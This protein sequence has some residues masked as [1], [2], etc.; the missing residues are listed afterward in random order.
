MARRRKAGERSTIDRLW[1]ASRGGLAVV[2]IFSAFVNVLKFAMP[3]YLLQVLDRIPASRSL[4]T[5]VM[6]TAITAVALAA[7]YALDIV[8]GRMMG[9]WSAWIEANLG[10]EIMRL[11]TGYGDARDE[12]NT[13]QALTDLAA[14]S[15]FAG[16]SMLRWLDLI[17]A[18]VFIFGVYL[19]HPVLGFVAIGATALLVLM[20][21]LQDRTTSPSRRAAS[22]ARRDGGE[23]VR[24]LDRNRESV[25]GLQ[26]GENLTAQWR[27]KETGRLVERQT[28]D[29]RGDMFRTLM[30]GLGQYMRIGL[31]AVGV[32]LV[33]LDQISLGSIFAAR[34]M[35]GFGFRLVEGAVRNW[36]GTRE[37]RD[38]YV[39]LVKHLSPADAA[40]VSVLKGIE[41][42]PM[43][44]DS[45]GHRYPY[46]RNSLFRRLS[47]SIEPGEFLLITGP[48]G[49]GKTTLT[50][51]LVGLIAPRYGTAR[52]GDVDVTRLPPD[53]RGRLIGYMP[54]HTELF[55]AT[56]RENIA[57]MGDAPLEEV[58]EVAKLVGIHD[59]VV[60]LPEGYDT[61]IGSGNS[62]ILS[63][64]QR[65]RIGMARAFFGHPR[66][67]VL[68]EPSANL[69]SPSRR[70]M[71]AAMKS[72]RAAGATI[73]A[74]QAI[75]SPR[76]SRLADR[77]LTLG[78]KIEITEKQRG[79]SRRAKLRT[80]K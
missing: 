74:T 15:R 65:K 40:P 75:D 56:I 24:T 10:P 45:V 30:G 14:V 58:V 18:P 51:I 59:F 38:A 21:V 22:A 46:Q 33:V 36:R 41:T 69:D 29:A 62:G 9:R 19:I 55:D 57:R 6:L 78:D 61:V 50:R 68:D 23:L 72:R 8:R 7:G 54:Q 35:A 3:L 60:E 49:A 25:G 13:D 37:A 80:V 34:V 64:S 1:R 77:N 32:W 66:L 43:V 4:E 53:M 71:E 28:T 20:G 12:Q 44:L 79:S 48:A 11:G 5:L 42:A 16:R 27:R 47:L 39:R 31:L 17:W 26:M 52:L 67:I 70:V 63:G 2:L 76:L 73:I